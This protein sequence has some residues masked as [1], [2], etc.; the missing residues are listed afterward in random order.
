MTSR[1]VISRQP[2]AALR[3]ELLAAHGK[4]T[5]E[6]LDRPGEEIP[7]HGDGLRWLRGFIALDH[8]TAGL[9]AD[10]P[11]LYSPLRRQ[12]QGLPDMPARSQLQ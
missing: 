11:A 4:P 6:R 3:R 10:C 12:L 9:A 2:A 7:R 8:E 1:L 5:G